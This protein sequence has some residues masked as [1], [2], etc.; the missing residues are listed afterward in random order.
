MG[1][2]TEAPGAN[3][4]VIKDGELYTPDSGCLLG[5]TRK[6]A[7]ELAGIVGIPTH[8]ERVSVKQLKEADEAFLASTAGGIMPINSVDDIILGG[9]N[10]PG[11]LTT[12]LHNMY[13]ERRWQ[14]W[15]GTPIDYTQRES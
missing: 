6:T 1:Y 11:E 12:K 13:W 3:I 9:E 10:G 15:L 5:I 14:G 2:L 7:L 4:F 8:I